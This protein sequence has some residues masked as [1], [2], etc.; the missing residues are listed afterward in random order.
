MGMLSY[1]FWF[2]FEWMAPFVEFL[3]LIFFIVLAILGKVNWFF[4]LCLLLI[5]YCFAFFISMLS[6]LAEETSYFK[7]TNKRDVSRMIFTALIEPIW[8]HP[9]VVWWSI[10][11]NFDLIKGKKSWGEMTRQG[12]VQYKNKPKTTGSSL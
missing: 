11:G 7:Y 2:F 10:K 1:P 12:F 8:F 4:F 5:V 3:G 9:R 6:L